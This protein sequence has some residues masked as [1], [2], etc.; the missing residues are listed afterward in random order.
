MSESIHEIQHPDQTISSATLQFHQDENDIWH[1]TIATRNRQWQSSS[2]GMQGLETAQVAVL[3]QLEAEGYQFFA[4]RQ[5]FEIPMLTPEQIQKTAQ[6]VR[7]QVENDDYVSI[8]CDG[9]SWRGCGS[10]ALA[11]LN[12][13]RQHFEPDGYRLLCYGASLNGS[14]SG[15]SRDSDMVHQLEWR[16]PFERARAKSTHNLFDTGP[17]VIPATYR[18]QQVFKEQW[19]AGVKLDRKGV[20]Y[21]LSAYPVVSVDR[22]GNLTRGYSG[23]NVVI[24]ETIGDIAL[25]MVFMPK[26]NFLMGIAREQSGRSSERYHRNEPQHEV[27]IR[28]PFWLGKYPITKAQWRAIATLPKVQDEMRPEPSEHRPHFDAN[29]ESHPISGVSW[30]EAGEFCRRLSAHTGHRYRLPTEAEWEYACKAGTTTPFH[31]W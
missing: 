18:E 12:D 3:K 20:A 11:A 4:N 9:R 5:R 8:T 6:V 25:E 23:Q 19:H 26:G 27:R 2:L 1:V 16:K 30:S 31:F 17:D 14:P 15:M 28:R 10:D 29:L 21:D 22:Q 7:W 13:V 24:T